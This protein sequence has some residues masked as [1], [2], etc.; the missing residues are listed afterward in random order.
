MHFVSA[1]EREELLPA[2]TQAVFMDNK[3]FTFGIGGHSRAITNTEVRVATPAG[4]E[5]YMNDT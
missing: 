3:T 1:A 4:P 2:G 5:K